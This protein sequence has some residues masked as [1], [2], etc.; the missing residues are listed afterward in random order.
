[1][2]FIIERFSISVF[3]NDFNNSE[4]GGNLKHALSYLQTIIDNRDIDAYDLLFGIESNMNYVDNF[5]IFSFL[6]HGSIFVYIILFISLYFLE[7]LIRN[8]DYIGLYFLVTS[9]VV[10][11]KGTFI[12]GNFYMFMVLFFML[13]WKGSVDY[14]FNNNSFN[15]K[16][17][18]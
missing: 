9:L 4:D 1:M 8:K 10:S 13:I 11:V 17:A 2:D 18:L 6:K 3:L 12:I 7:K 15:L 16:K 14:S 5:Y